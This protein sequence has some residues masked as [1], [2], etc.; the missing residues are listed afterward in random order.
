MGLGVAGAVV[1]V[2]AGPWLEGWVTGRD[3]RVGILAARSG[4]TQWG[5]GVVETVLTGLV[6]AAAVSLLEG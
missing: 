3:A 2:A 5:L 6:S 1:P 4:C